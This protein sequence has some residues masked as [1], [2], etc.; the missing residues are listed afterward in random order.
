MK[1]VLFALLVLILLSGCA[2][3]PRKAAQ[4]DQ[5]RLE[6]KQNAMNMEQARMQKAALDAVQLQNAQ[7]EAGHKQATAQAWRNGWNMTLKFAFYVFTA[8]LCYVLFMA[9]RSIATS[10]A[11]TTEGLSAAIVRAAEVKANLIQLDPVTRQYPLFIQHIGKGRFSALDMNRN[12]VLLLDT[13]SEPDRQMIATAGAVQ[14]A[15]ALA[16]EARQAHDPAGVSML[17]TPIVDVKDEMIRIGAEMW[18]NHE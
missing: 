11:T 4:A 8:G 6:A 15:G 17:Q 7:V 9:S 12:I 13:R 1:R 3:D 5:I 16:R 14:Y 10:F 18:S 2:P